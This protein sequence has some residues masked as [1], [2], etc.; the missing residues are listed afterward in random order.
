[1]PAA[2]EPNISPP[3]ISL[4]VTARNDDHGGNLLSRMQAFVNGWIEQ[5]RR[6][7][8]PSE[9]IIVEWNPPQDRLRLA[10]ALH[11]PEDLGPCQARFIEVPP[12]VH[13]RFAHAEAL[14][15]YQMIA[16]N[17]GIRRARGRFVLVTN[18]DILFS[19][20]LARF[21]GEQR[22]QPDRMYRMD[23]HD[24]MSQVPV[25]API[26]EQLDYCRTHLIRIN[27]REGTYNVSPEGR[28]I[29]SPGD[30]A[31][32]DSGILF[33]KGWLPVER[34]TAQEPFRWAGQNAELLLD[35]P[36]ESVSALLLDLEPGP[37]TGNAPLDLEVIGDDFEVLAHVTVDRRSRFRLPLSTRVPARM[38]FRVHHG[39]VPTDRDPRILNFRAFRFDWER[40]VE[41]RSGSG[42]AT[43]RPIGR[44]NLVAASW[45]ALQHVIDRLA[46]GGRLV[47][48]TVPV[49]PRMRRM[50]K[51]YVEWRGFAGMARNAVPYFKRRLSFQAKA[52]SGE[53]IFAPH[54]GLTPGAGWQMLDDYRGESF[55]R[56]SDGAEVIVA[57][58]AGGS[59]E[60][61]LQ[62][63]PFPSS[64]QPLD[65]V[66][67]DAT[68]QPIAQRRVAGLAFIRFGIPHTPG[69]TQVLR[70]GVREVGPSLDAG[71]QE[72]KVYWC[73][74]ISSPRPANRS[75]LSQ[76]WGAG[77][78]W[79]PANSAM[80]ALAAAELVVRTPQQAAPLFID[81]ETP[82][83]SEFQ[84]RDVGGKV[85]ATFN[86][87][88][89]AVHRMDLPLVP[90][91]THLLELTS[92]GTFRAYGCD[93]T[94]TPGQSPA[95][96]VH[97]NA[98]GDFTL[99][100]REHWFDLRGYPEFDLFS[101]NL[102]SVLCVAAHHGGAREEMLADP[103]RIYHIEHGTGSGWTPEGQ[104]KLFE[105]I[106]ARGLSFVDNEEVLGWAAQMSR[107]NAPMIFN[108][109]NWG[110]VE[111]DLKETVLPGEA[112]L[113]LSI[114]KM[115]RTAG[116]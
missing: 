104:A 108:H 81:L 84:V 62:V 66:L 92:P 61:G 56:A 42:A 65:L 95:A 53:D 20:E 91:R 71:S 18:I 3:Y 39:G 85:L 75:T 14:P 47:R 44:R 68:G 93:W 43:L 6:H 88:G 102:D 67:L 107:L 30:I 105:R 64:T 79:D 60:L 36:H 38:W 58:S 4:V 32:T 12:E 82:E 116:D 34:Y 55:R 28:S 22:L 10:E 72:V 69:R 8:I 90:G 59:G 50:L 109:E 78:R 86:A 2:G 96:F 1:M 35:R 31:S 74:W 21:L 51:S 57:A 33:G 24:V 80:T 41:S 115:P 70:L 48:L 63:E 77:W 100:A 17:V 114:H 5:A 49:S 113:P 83:P 13:Q 11:W 111:F 9:M 97:T 54:S 16:K 19:S 89:R 45:F 101:M 37:G 103:M 94:P 52:R 106:A 23:R 112:D 98:C 26:E 73:G 99:M 15:L 7:H 29:L 110:L 40:R 27:V 46:K 25:D 87:N 76:P